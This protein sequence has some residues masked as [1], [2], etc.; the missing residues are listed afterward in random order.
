M[1]DHL[2][3][4]P[5]AVVFELLRSI[6]GAFLFEADIPSPFE[7]PGDD[8][9]EILEKAQALHGEW[10]AI[11]SVVPS[12]HRL[13]TLVPELAEPEVV[14]DA[15]RWRVLVAVAGGRTVAE[16][17]DVLGLTELETCRLVKDAVEGGLVAL[18]DEDVVGELEEGTD[19]AAAY[20]P[21]GY[22][23]A[24]GYDAE[25]YDDAAPEVGAY[26]AGYETGAYDTGG[27]DTG[28]YEAV[29]LDGGATSAGYEP[30][31]WA[32]EPPME[33]DAGEGWTGDAEADAAAVATDEEPAAEEETTS[34]G[35]WDPLAPS[36]PSGLEEAWAADAASL[37]AFGT[38]L[39]PP[40]TLAEAL[41][42]AGGE[43]DPAVELGELTPKAARAIAAAAQ[44]QTEAERDA[45]LAEAVDEDDEPIDRG[46]LLR[47][48]SSVKQ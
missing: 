35:G 27:Y 8:V 14:V 42:S 17:A 2:D 10:E 22:A 6:D 5:V 43:L 25:G 40:A 26:D 38:P 4:D 24:A 28:S 44:A 9:A 34:W 29:A 41:G 21:D 36:A 46:L 31:S 47:F 11:T 30:G 16:V 1:D 7:G 12:V 3:Q 13:V 48:L 39:P 18:G 20:D 32:V 19:P 33:P 23:P 37:P 15:A 45:A